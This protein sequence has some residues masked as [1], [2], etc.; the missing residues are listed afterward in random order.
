MLQAQD[1]A[2]KIKSNQVKDEVAEIE[3]RLEF[4]RAR[5]A[6]RA[7]P[8]GADAQ[9]GP[10]GLEAADDE[11]EKA[12]AELQK[13]RYRWEQA[14]QDA[15]EV[16]LELQKHAEV[17][18]HVLAGLILEDILQSVHEEAEVAPELAALRAEIHDL[19]QQRKSIKERMK[20][21][22]AET[23]DASAKV[24]ERVQAVEAM[25][26][27]LEPCALYV[28]YGGE[29]VVTRCRLRSARGSGIVAGPRALAVARGVSITHC[30]RHGVL[31]HNGG[32]IV[33][34]SVSIL[35]CRQ[36]GA[37]A[38]H[39][40]LLPT[41]HAQAR[42][43]DDGSGGSDHDTAEPSSADAAGYAMKPKT[44]K[45][46]NMLH[47]ELRPASP[48]ALSRAGTGHLDS[49]PKS[50]ASGRSAGTVDVDLAP[51]FEK[52][53]ASTVHFG[54]PAI[55]AR[56]TTMAYNG[57]AGVAGDSGAELELD[58][59]GL[60]SNRREGLVLSGEGTLA[61]VRELTAASNGA[62]GIHVKMHALAVAKNSSI[63]GNGQHGCL[64]AG[65]HS[66]LKLHG[67]T[68]Q[69]NGL[70]GV[71][72]RSGGLVALRAH[73]LVHRNYRVMPSAAQARVEGAGSWLDV[74]ASTVGDAAQAYP[75]HVACENGGRAH[76]HWP[77]QLEVVQDPGA[78][79]EGSYKLYRKDG[80]SLTVDQGQTLVAGEQPINI[81]C[82]AGPDLG[83]PVVREFVWITSAAAC[84]PFELSL[85]VRKAVQAQD[86]AEAS[87]PR[88]QRKPP[89]MLPSAAAAAWRLFYTER[90]SRD[91]SVGY[92]G[93][94][95]GPL[96]KVPIWD[97]L[98]H[99]VSLHLFPNDKAGPEAKRQEALEQ[100]RMAHKLAQVAH[101]RE[102]ERESKLS[103]MYPEQRDAALLDEQNRQ[104]RRRRHLLHMR[105]VRAEKEGR[106]HAPIPQKQTETQVRTGYGE[107]WD[108]RSLA[109]VAPNARGS[110]LLDAL[111]ARDATDWV[112]MTEDVSGDTYWWN[113]VSGDISWADPSQASGVGRAGLGAR[114]DSG[115]ARGQV[116]G[117]E[118][119][120]G[121]K[122][123]QA[124]AED[125]EALRAVWTAARDK[126][127]SEQDLRAALQ[128]LK[129]PGASMPSYHDLHRI[130]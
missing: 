118:A 26:R 80:R 113:V 55:V 82:H 116:D 63:L 102:L 89:L 72:I 103:R 14:M 128:R 37:L 44:P 61:S 38:L 90:A 5:L 29:V 21:V 68:V 117:Q 98:P 83:S 79:A 91:L 54:P 96:V 27:Q 84:N 57:V 49:R 111:S 107:R 66:T 22:L 62:Q 70:E 87:L 93:D 94:L 53:V 121:V 31:C 42:Q 64:V 86:S 120:D 33:L 60:F 52:R 88:R 1:R 58:A 34:D 23:E 100:R 65:H 47:Q 119:K 77:P 69:L 56:K 71:E 74:E 9:I 25:R 67:G 10:Q 75:A 104:E 130:I 46:P 15:A 127:A 18:S 45:T 16:A 4:L 101:Q 8:N 123:A 28:A 99:M 43:D 30:G 85:F 32:R 73:A 81:K 124:D 13:A 92:E 126:D 109:S 12:E 59:C 2:A 11:R 115:N 35:H 106:L 129:T 105:R 114:A 97:V 7:E 40:N 3:A 19:R 48:L 51:P 17:A 112:A 95:I 20:Q 76:L 36:Y 125:D 110:T 78:E 6:A 24:H 39:A 108:T 50:R 41:A 122:D